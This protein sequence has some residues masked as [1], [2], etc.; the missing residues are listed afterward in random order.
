MV[1]F[2]HCLFIHPVLTPM[3]F[4]VVSVSCG[5]T[6]KNMGDITLTVRLG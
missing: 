2:I 5:T 3:K 6:V 4:A 1:Y